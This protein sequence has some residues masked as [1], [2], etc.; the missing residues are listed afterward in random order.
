LPATPPAKGSLVPKSHM[1]WSAVYIGYYVNGAWQCW[2]TNDKSFKILDNGWAFTISGADKGGAVLWFN[3]DGSTF[4]GYGMSL[5]LGMFEITGTYT[6]GANGLVNGTYSLTD[7]SGTP[8]LSPNGTGTIT[9]TLN[10]NATTMTLTLKNTSNVALFTMSG[11]W[12]PFSGLTM[13][14]TWTVQISASIK[15][16]GNVKGAINSLTIGAVEETNNN[17]E[18][19]ANL[20]AIS[21][22]GSLGNATISFGEAGEADIV[23]T[24]YKTPTGNVVYGIYDNLIVNGNPETGTISG[25]LNPT[26]GKFTFNLTSTNGNRYTFVGAPTP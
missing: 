19:C 5:K 6:V 11:V 17:N 15:G 14:E 24:P 23:F 10:L 20:F 25:T 7:L 26:T 18:P 13:P 4:D 9:G 2:D 8:L 16:V 21:G 1:A 3:T 12:D 22:S